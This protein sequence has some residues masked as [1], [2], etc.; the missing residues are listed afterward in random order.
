MAFSRTN[1]YQI[2]VGAYPR[3]AWLYD[4]LDAAT[5]VDTVGYFNNAANELSLG[6]V[7]FVHV[8]TTAIGT[9]GT[10]GAISVCFVNSLAAAAV[11][12]SDATSIAPVTDTR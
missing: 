3:R 11:D 4:T 10:P 7:I 12:T 1:L 8:W 6:D 2:G 9:G 5:V